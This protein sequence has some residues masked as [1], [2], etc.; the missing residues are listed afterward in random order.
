MNWIMKLYEKL[1][2]VDAKVEV[3]PI[4]KAINKA[5]DKIIGPLVT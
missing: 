4:P 5:T 2:K 3:R 1:V